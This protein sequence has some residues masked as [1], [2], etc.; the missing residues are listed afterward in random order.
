MKLEEI[1]ENKDGRITAF[2]CRCSPESKADADMVMQET[3]RRL[4]DM[5]YKDI[6]PGN[7]L[8]AIV[9]SLNWDFGAEIMGI[10]NDQC[11]WSRLIPIA[12]RRR[13]RFMS[14]QCDDVE[15]GIAAAWLAHALYSRYDGRDEGPTPDPAE[16]PA[17]RGQ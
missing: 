15:D 12:V 1:F 13:T 7:L 2:L 3:C 5:G 8:S 16:T 9:V 14:V 10:H 11:R 4:K 17:D 6:G